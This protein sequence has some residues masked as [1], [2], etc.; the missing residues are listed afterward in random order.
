[1]FENFLNAF[2][3]EHEFSAP[4]NWASLAGQIQRELGCVVPE[5]IVSFW[6]EIGA[7]YFGDRVLYFFGDQV[8]GA[9]RDSLLAWNGKDFWRSI[10]PLPRDGGPV[11]F[12]ETCFGDQLGFRRESNGELVYVLFSVDTFDAY[13]VARGEGHGLGLKGL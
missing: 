4:V 13:T 9:P 1:M 2:P 8:E 10:Y 11:F 12:A 6:R 3:Q 5:E 7:G